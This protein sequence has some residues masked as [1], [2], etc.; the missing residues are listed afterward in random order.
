MIYTSTHTVYT[1][2]VN[3][4]SWCTDRYSNCEL[5]SS[6]TKCKYGYGSIF[7]GYEGYDDR[8]RDGVCYKDHPDDF[9]TRLTLPSPRAAPRPCS[10][11]HQRSL[12]TS[13]GIPASFPGSLP[14]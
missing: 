5:D 3:K 9:T 11:F 7:D 4:S 13:N 6:G 2:Q 12:R 8:Y 10:R 1:H 14:I